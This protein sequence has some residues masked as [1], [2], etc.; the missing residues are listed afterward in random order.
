M[1]QRATD[2]AAVALVLGTSLLVVQA[3]WDPATVSPAEAQHRVGERV[4][5]EGLILDVRSFDDGSGRFTLAA[6]GAAIHARYR[7]GLVP[8][9]SAW[10]RATGTV[11]RDAGV[12][13]LEVDALVEIATNQAPTM[14][15]A[16]VALEPQEYALQ[17]VQVQGYA[18]RQSLRAD[19]VS[20]ALRGAIPDEG[21]YTVSG[22]L[23]FERDCVC[24]ALHVAEAA[25]WTS[26]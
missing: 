7:A 1:F 22:V 18:E 8:V 14:S 26:F 13:L 10:G 25:P 5:V 24:Y 17:R 19:G 23:R 4:H 20:L 6:D 3:Q 9:E 16:V 21:R 11:G 15:L 12:P 2:L